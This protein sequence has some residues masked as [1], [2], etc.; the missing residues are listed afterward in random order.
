M[1]V[2]RAPRLE[3]R[4][5]E[6][7]A[8]IHGLRHD[9]ADRIRTPNRWEGS[10]RRTSQARAIRGSN[11]IEGY[12][13][14]QQDAIAAVDDE[15]PLTADE[16]TWAE[17]VGYR[18]ALTFVLNVVRSGGIALDA[19]TIRT[20]HFMLL[21][22]DLRKAPGQYRPGE[23]YVDDGA[24]GRR[25]YVGP[26]PDLVPDLMEQ[27]V[28]HLGERDGV[29]PLVR[30]AMAHLNLVMI[31]PFRDGNA[32]MA[33]VLQTAALAQDSVLEPVFSSIE[34]WLGANTPDYYAILAK[35]GQGTWNPGND[36][37]PWVRF[38]LRAHSMQ[39]Q[40]QARRFDE[41]ARLWLRIDDLIAEHRLDERT[42]NALFD[43]AVGVRVARPGYA[44]RAEVEERTAT[45]DLVRLADL[46]LLDA[47]GKTRAR[48][49][50]AGPVLR[51]A[52]RDARA[53]RTP[54]ADPYPELRNT[55]RGSQI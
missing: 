28:E 21:E 7:L 9:L 11:S 29:D 8:Q 37:L 23:I 46:G 49:Y 3:P 16:R 44:Q 53:E 10:L 51:D 48:H 52:V 14:S 20:M 32:R 6:V 4:D 55:S 36:P 41:A 39:A 30:G 17:I 42:E 50:L 45:R 1:P 54:L 5:H 38:V 15:E 34:E 13:I 47:I 19:Q 22:H 33:R 43:A 26:D 18:R 40:T 27:M 31:H 12:D 25:V 24:D 35:V 2:Y